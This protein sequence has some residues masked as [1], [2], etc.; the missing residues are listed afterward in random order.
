M[1]SVTILPR[2]VSCA[3]RQTNSWNLSSFP[4]RGQV[5]SMRVISFVYILKAFPLIRRSMTSPAGLL[6]LIK[7]LLNWFSLEREPWGPPTCPSPGRSLLGESSKLDMLEFLRGC[8]NVAEAL[9]TGDPMGE[10]L[11]LHSKHVT[12]YEMTVTKNSDEGWRLLL[13]SSSSFF[14]SPSNENPAWAFLGGLTGANSSQQDD[15][16]ATDE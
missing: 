16:G 5:V 12:N 11:A 15:K 6:L 10:L 3:A 1:R 8:S 9:L 7:Y 14:N 2:R 13:S 4:R